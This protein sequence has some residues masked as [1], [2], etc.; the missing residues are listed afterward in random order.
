MGFQT[1]VNNNPAP[2]VEGDFASATAYRHTVL[3]DEAAFVADEAGVAVGTMAF[4]NSTTGLASN[5][6]NGGPF[7][8][9]VQRDQP[10]V[11]TEWLASAS[12]V[13]QS[14]LEVTL[15]DRGDFWARFAAGATVGQKVYANLTTGALTA[16]ATGSPTAGASVTASIAGTTMTVTAVGSGT[17]AVGQVLSG[18]NVTDDT[19]IT[20]LGTGTGG[21]GTYT[22]STSQTAASATVTSVAN[23]ETD[24]YVAST[25]GAGELSKITTVKV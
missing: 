9:F 22:V 10:V 6:W 5:T 18:A 19:Y 21:T 4:A 20:A 3:A 23:V 13:V 16:A 2:A 17:L 25:S 7:I 11:I 12:L 8:G 15:F 24:F 14:G 1:Q